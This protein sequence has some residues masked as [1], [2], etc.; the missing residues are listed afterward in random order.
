VLGKAAAKTV[1]AHGWFNGSL[2]VLGQFKGK[3]NS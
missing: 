2:A 1:L 3:G